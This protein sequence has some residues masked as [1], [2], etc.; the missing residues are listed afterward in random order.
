MLGAPIGIVLLLSRHE[1]LLRWLVLAVTTLT[2]LAL[3]MGWRRTTREGVRARLSIGFATGLVGGATGLNGP[4]MVL[5]QLSSADGAARSRANTIVFLT[6]S[7]LLMLPLLAVQGGVSAQALWIGMLMLPA[8]GIGTLI[9]Q[10]LFAPALES[11][12]RRAA[13]GIIGAAI[14]AGLPVWGA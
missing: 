13:Y 4:V 10:A 14:V 11:L 2:L 12:Y 3:L 6:L 5:F 9:G 7:S 8:Y 1:G